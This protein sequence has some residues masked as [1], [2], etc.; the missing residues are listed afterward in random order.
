MASERRIYILAEVKSGSGAS[1][2][3]KAEKIERRR[4]SSAPKETGGLH[5]R[6][7]LLT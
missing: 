7:D 6:I 2:T 3:C 4:T 1:E 5:I